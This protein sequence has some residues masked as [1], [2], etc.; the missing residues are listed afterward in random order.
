MDSM[1][2]HTYMKPLDRELVLLRR[3]LA[4]SVVA[5]IV[6]LTIDPSHF[7]FRPKATE[8]EGSINIDLIAFDTNPPKESEEGAPPEPLLPQMPKKFELEIPKKPDELSFDE[9]KEPVLDEPKIKIEQKKIDED[10]L[11]K[12]SLDRLVKEL[13]HQKEKENKNKKSLLTDSLRERKKDLETGLLHG[14]LTL[15]STEGGYTS[16]VKAWIKRNYSLPE[17]SDLKDGNT[18]AVLHLVINSEG[19]IAHLS[20]ESSSGN[21]VFDELAL[22]TIENSAPFPPP[23]QEWVGKTLTIPVETKIG[24]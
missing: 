2:R 20:L 18:R 5:H 19:G 21:P 9:K 1:R 23:P 15:G 8:D 10:Q 12:V 4:F 13:N 24:S 7:F 16:L 22:K 17:I 11:T 3:F 14:T 6:L